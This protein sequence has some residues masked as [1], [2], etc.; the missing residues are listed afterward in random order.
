MR[1]ALRVYAVLHSNHPLADEP[2]TTFDGKIRTFQTM[3]S[4][5][6]KIRENKKL[7]SFLNKLAEK[8]STTDEES[9]SLCEKFCE[10]AGIWKTNAID[11]PV[12]EGS[13]KILGSAIYIRGSYFNHSCR[14]T[15][16]FQFTGQG[17]EL[18]VRAIDD[19]STS[20]KASVSYLKPFI[21]KEERLRELEEKYHFNCGCDLCNDKI[22]DLDTDGY[23]RLKNQLTLIPR[24]DEDYEGIIAHCVEPLK[25]LR[26]LYPSYYDPVV[27]TLFL[28][29]QQVATAGAPN[30]VIRTLATE[31]IT[32]LNNS[33][34]PDC[35]YMKRVKD[36]LAER[37]LSSEFE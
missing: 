4:H 8:L 10:Y 32:H 12:E 34:G 31:C 26:R 33:F 23:T 36:I 3:E 6:D 25:E 13:K 28:Q 1:Q 11:M 19:I 22:K 35:L 20:D 30:D 16:I 18:E 27:D 9:N 7:V 29:F 14:P 2:C 21:E 15:A 37:G 5:A 24:M 17:Q